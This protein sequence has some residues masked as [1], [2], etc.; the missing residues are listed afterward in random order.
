M[1]LS[2][3]LG[4]I[5]ITSPEDSD[6]CNAGWKC[7]IF[8]LYFLTPGRRNPRVALTKVINKQ[9]I[10]GYCHCQMVE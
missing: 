10:K 6:R 7:D 8:T 4:I 5:N 2:Q 9:S 3:S 1:H